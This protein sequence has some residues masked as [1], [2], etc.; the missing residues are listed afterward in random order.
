[1]RRRPAL[2]AYVRRIRSQSVGRT[3][4]DLANPS[5]VIRHASRFVAGRT[6]R[7]NEY[8]PSF[9]RDEEAQF[10]AA[11]TGHE[12]TA[13]DDAFAELEADQAFIDDVKSHYAM[14]RRESTLHIG[15]FRILYAIVRLTEPSTLVETGVHDG[16]S[17]AVILR[18]LD[19]NGHGRLT[20]I[21]LPSTDQPT[22]EGPGWLVPEA[23]RP[24]WELQLGDARDHLPRVVAAS[25]PVDIFFHDSDHSGPHQEFEFRTVQPYPATFAV[26]LS[27]QDYPTEALLDRLSAE[28]GLTHYRVRTAAGE[29]GDFMGGLSAR[30]SHASSG[31]SSAGVDATAT[32]RRSSPRNAEA[33]RWSASGRK[34]IPRAI[35]SFLQSGRPT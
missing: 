25:A 31:S 30:G 20:S 3:L 10:V 21:D 5:K 23:L 13:A 8:A 27:D 28:W 19:R 33:S 4:R 15:R 35:S 26:L 12:R 9:S 18:A 17:S 32:W 7:T 34:Q 1:M 2:D 29:P 24:R 14:V 16:L 22:S 11:V 6:E